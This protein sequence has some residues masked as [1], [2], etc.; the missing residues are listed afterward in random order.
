M[1]PATRRRGFTLIELLVVIAIIAILVAILLPAVQ[2]AREAA[3][4]SQCKNNLKQLGL[5][6]ANYESTYGVIPQKQ[7]GTWRSSQWTPPHRR[8]PRRFS[9][10]YS[11][12]PYM[13]QIGL[14]DMINTGGP[15]A[16]NNGTTNFYPAGGN[17]PSPWTNNY[18]P[19][20]TQIPIL[21]CPSDPR[22]SSDV[23]KAVTN[24]GFS[25]GDS[26]WDN[27]AQW[28][29][30]G[31]RGLRGMFVGGIRNA[32]TRS[33][34]DVTDGLSN[35]IAMSEKIIAQNGSRRPEDG[36]TSHA[37]SNAWRRA[38]NGGV[39]LCLTSVDPATGEYVGA[40]HRHSGK[41]W[42]D[43]APLF[44]AVTTIL[45]PN[46]PECEAAGWSDWS[47][48]INDPKSRHAGGVQAVMGDG[49]VVF[50]NE[51]IDVGDSSY[52]NPGNNNSGLS[53][54]SPF[55]VWGA[56]GSVNGGDSADAGF[57]GT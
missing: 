55:G 44:T 13:D 51:N 23:A 40:I 25:M 10:F 56:L 6:I 7:V 48:T 22:G 17:I 24:Y 2:Q 18:I 27:C 12:L 20:R 35:T 54:P 26:Y 34:R 39:G 49:R 30:N 43:G 11:M 53:G 50:F 4:R 19:V 45:G 8:W 15:A 52:G 9:G 29:G 33:Y 28:N 47:D 42:L 21:K 16:A 38:S 3:R 46:T 5:A 57:G 36:I 37:I 31:G 1:R 32:G 14:Y 41:R